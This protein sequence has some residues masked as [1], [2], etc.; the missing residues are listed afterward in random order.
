M[1]ATKY[2]TDRVKL[3]GT[4]AMRAVL[5]SKNGTNSASMQRANNSNPL[6]P[7]VE[8]MATQRKG[9]LPAQIEKQGQRQYSIHRSCTD[10]YELSGRS[11]ETSASND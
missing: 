8:E 10:Q 11:L 9:E 2:S 5:E 3:G 1:V 7:A 4:N 6:D